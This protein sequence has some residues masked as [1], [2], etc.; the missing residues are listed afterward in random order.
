[1]SAW[2]ARRLEGAGADLRFRMKHAAPGRQ[3]KSPS[4]RP[5]VWGHQCLGHTAWGLEVPGLGAPQ[6]REP[7]RSHRAAP[8]SPPTAPAG[9]SAPHGLPRHRTPRGS[10]GGARPAAHRRVVRPGA[11]APRCAQLPALTLTPARGRGLLGDTEACGGRGPFPASAVPTAATLR[12]TPRCALV[13]G[14]RH[15]PL[16]RWPLSPHRCPAPEAG[17]CSERCWPRGRP[18]PARSDGTVLHH[19]PE[20]DNN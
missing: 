8:R 14:R 6:P 1:M 7:L 11:G 9:P 15:A 3:A 13:P 5:Q 19:V 16:C 18:P 2:G 4:C 12:V 10:G 17:F 20:P